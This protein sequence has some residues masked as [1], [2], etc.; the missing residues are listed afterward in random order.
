MASERVRKGIVPM[1]AVTGP[2]PDEGDESWE[3]V[4]RAIDTHRCSNRKLFPDL[5]PH[6]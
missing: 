5:E 1:K 3:E 6:T 4:L 2:L